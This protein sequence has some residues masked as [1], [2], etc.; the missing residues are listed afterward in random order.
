MKVLVAT[1]DGQSM[2]KN[3][4]S[5]TN[6]GE[7]VGF[8]FECEG[9]QVD[10]SCGCRRAFGGLSSHK[11]TTTAG[12]IQKE[13]TESQYLELYLR[14]RREAGWLKESDDCS[15]A[16]AEARDMLRIAAAF[17]VGAIL[18]KRGNKVQA[19]KTTMNGRTRR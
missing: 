11:S 17:P 4:F 2:R 3:D 1:K 10:G 5:H 8:V 16:E 15:W 6:D 7:F 18:E 14:S 9:E 19:R 13:L 12:V